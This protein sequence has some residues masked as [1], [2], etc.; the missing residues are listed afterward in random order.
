MTW[1]KPK[2]FEYG[3]LP[4]SSVYR[5]EKIYASCPNLDFIAGEYLAE[6]GETLEPTT[7][8]N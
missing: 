3:T 2:S 5:R 4:I 8:G 6:N 7:N 1:W